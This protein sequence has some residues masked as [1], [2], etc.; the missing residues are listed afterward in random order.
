MTEAELDA[1]LF[2]N[3]SR[4]TAARRAPIAFAHV[5]S[6]LSRAGV[7]LQL[8]WSE[9]QESAATCGEGAKAYQYCQFL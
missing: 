8:L 1:A 4:N 3:A 7:T 5:H 6:E 2:R 9:Y